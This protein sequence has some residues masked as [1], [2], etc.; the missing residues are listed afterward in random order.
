[1]RL[2]FAFPGNLDLKTGGY[3]YDRRLIAELEALGWQVDLLPLGDGFPHPDAAVLEAAE[4][5][6]S[7]LRDDTLV[8]IDGLAFGVLDQWAARQA[9]RLIVVAL[10]HHPLAFETGLS[11]DRAEALL[12]SEAGALSHARH[13]IVTSPETARALVAG[14]GVAEENISIA[15]PGTDR[16]ASAAAC[17]EVPHILSVGALTPRKGHDV[18]VDALKRVE[19][20]SWTATIVGSPSLDVDMAAKIARQIDDLGLGERITLAGTVEDIG[21]FFAGADLFALASRY[22]GYGMVFAEALAH[23]LPIIACRAGAVPDV[24]P[25]T[26]GILVPVDDGDAFAGALR[27]LICDAGLR[28]QKTEGARQAGARL[29]GWAQTGRLVSDVLEQMR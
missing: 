27:S 12:R 29:P 28:R 22:E 3:G 20:L 18:L 23:G 10:V 26:A 4:N 21:P 8:M 5:A 7:A 25:E 17:N 13:V 6:L 14:Y 1:M 2:V 15:A 11:Q 24:V 16:P 19:D 9:G